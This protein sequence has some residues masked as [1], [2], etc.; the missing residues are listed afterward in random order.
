VHGLISVTD[1]VMAYIND[2]EERNE[3]LDEHVI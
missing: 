3:W 1:E 2:L